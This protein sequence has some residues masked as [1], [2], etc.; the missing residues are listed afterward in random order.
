MG[1]GQPASA[2]GFA[3]GSRLCELGHPPPSIVNHVSVCRLSVRLSCEANK[4]FPLSI[5]AHRAFRAPSLT[6]L[7]RDNH[8]FSRSGCSAPESFFRVSIFDGFETTEPVSYPPGS[9]PTPGVTKLP[10]TPS[11]PVESSAFAPVP[12]RIFLL[13]FHPP[14]AYGPLRSHSLRVRRL[15]L[16]LPRRFEDSHLLLQSH[17][18]CFLEA[19]CLSCPGSSPLRSVRCLRHPVRG[20]PKE[21]GHRPYVRTH[22]YATV[23]QS[24]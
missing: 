14:L 10:V 24:L 17:R 1:G 22:P 13:L 20:C 8:S 11:V 15:P 7:I 16:A 19:G 2:S 3:L 4:L 18:V 9:L 12:R 6:P 5:A 21:T 23:A